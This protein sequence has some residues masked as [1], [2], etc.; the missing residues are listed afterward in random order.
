MMGFN[1]N[2]DKKM[3]NTLRKKGKNISGKIRI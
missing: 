1:I 2:I 3:D